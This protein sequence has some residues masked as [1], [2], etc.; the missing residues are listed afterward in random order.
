MY[1]NETN[2]TQAF[3][4]LHEPE[5]CYVPNNVTRIYINIIYLQKRYANPKTVCVQDN[6]TRT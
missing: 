6:V 2:M 1:Q 3:K 4:K 5:N